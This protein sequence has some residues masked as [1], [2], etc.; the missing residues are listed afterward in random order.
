MDTNSAMAKLEE[1][2]SAINEK[3]RQIQYFDNEREENR[4]AYYR[5]LLIMFAEVFVL[6]L[7]SLMS[8]KLLFPVIVICAVIFYFRR[9][10]PLRKDMK[11]CEKKIADL[12]KDIN[13]LRTQLNMRAGAMG[14]GNTH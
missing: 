5:F 12:T 8:M 6:G 11:D 1:I 13:R 4:T 2:Q 3:Q 10:R 9:I 7:L 14:V